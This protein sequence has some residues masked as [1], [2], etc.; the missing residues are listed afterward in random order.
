[1]SASYDPIYETDLDSQVFGDREFI[2]V[3]WGKKETQ[4][5]GSEGKQA[6]KRKLDLNSMSL[7]PDDNG[8]I[9]ITWRGDSELFAIHYVAIDHRKFKVYDKE[10]R[11]QFTS[12]NCIGLGH[13]IAWKPSGSLIAVQQ[14]TVNEKYMIALFEKNGLRH[15]EIELPFSYNEVIVITSHLYNSVFNMF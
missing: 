11:L 12:E 13:L 2:N 3:G 6:A 1:M 8:Q 4:F 10:G 14:V 9:S 5:H 15:R 7:L